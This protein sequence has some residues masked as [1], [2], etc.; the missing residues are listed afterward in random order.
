MNIYI[1]KDIIEKDICCKNVIYLESKALI[2]E[3]FTCSNTISKE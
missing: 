3:I 2:Y 1:Y